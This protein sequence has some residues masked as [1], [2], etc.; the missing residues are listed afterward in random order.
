M[1]PTSTVVRAMQEALSWILPVECAGCDL[2]DVA[3]CDSCRAHLV[4]VQPVIRNLDG[5]RVVSAHRYEGV[6]ER[7]IGSLKNDGRVGLARPLG[8]SLAGAADALDAPKSTRFVPVPTT[9]AAFGSRGFRVVETLCRRAGIVCTPAL[10]PTRAAA[11]QRRLGREAR[12]GNVAGLFRSAPMHGS[13]VVVVDDVVTTGATL[14]EA[15]RALRAAGGEVL[16]ALTVA[17]TPRR[18]AHSEN[19]DQGPKNGW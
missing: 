6:V 14:R 4:R 15:A 17:S 19:A 11:D 2:P 7:V 1:P 3:L 16:G 18:S 13:L 8:R 5:M 9:R 10:A 12:R